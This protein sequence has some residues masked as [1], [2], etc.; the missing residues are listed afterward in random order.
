VLFLRQWESRVARETRQ[1]DACLNSTA[2][3]FGIR[4]QGITSIDSDLRLHRIIPRRTS[5][6]LEGIELIR[7]KVIELGECPPPRK[8]GDGTIVK[9]TQHG[10][11]V[12][13][14]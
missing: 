8:S 2:E 10:K 11:N 1:W 12:N 14:P 9:E 4:P 13:H 6:S 5:Q 3:E 7:T